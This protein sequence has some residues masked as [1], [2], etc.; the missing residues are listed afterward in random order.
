MLY[1]LKTSKAF[2]KPKCG[3][4]GRAAELV[5]EDPYAVQ[6]VSWCP[7]SRLLCVV[8]TSAHVI[9]YRFSKHDA[10]TQIVVSP[11]YIRVCVCWSGVCVCV[12]VGCVSVLEWGVCVCVFGGDF[13]CHF[14][15]A[16]EEGN[17][18]ASFFCSFVVSE[19]SF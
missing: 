4:G 13:R 12:G 19:L 5:E 7:N 9:L 11:L 18:L 14:R 17:F 15:A 8:G 3:E 16:S 2:E 10:N 6:M 1:K